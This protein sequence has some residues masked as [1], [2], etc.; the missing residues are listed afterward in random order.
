MARLRDI[1]IYIE[2]YGKGFAVKRIRGEKEADITGLHRKP[3]KSQDKGLTI[4]WRLKL[5]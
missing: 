2:R 4:Q 5:A 1:W 3:M